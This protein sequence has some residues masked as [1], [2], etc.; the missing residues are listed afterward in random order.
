M[1][2][3]PAGS[4]AE[5]EAAQEKEAGDGGDTDGGNGAE[6]K[7]VAPAL[8]PDMVPG[9][10][11]VR[12]SRAPVM[13]YFAIN[14]DVLIE[15]GPSSGSY[16][17]TFECI[18][19]GCAGQCG[20]MRRIIHK[21]GKAVATSIDRSVVHLRACSR[22]PTWTRTTSACSSWWALTSRSSS[23]PSQQSRSATTPSFAAKVELTSRSRWAE[24]WYS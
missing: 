14:S 19:N 17:V 22:T 7:S 8:K 2:P 3:K 10:P 16:A 5:K 21:D 23:R 4:G 1:L 15:M 11:H 12:L 24:W 13:K 18:I 9:F 20:T 6:T